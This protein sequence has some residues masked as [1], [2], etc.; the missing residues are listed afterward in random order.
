MAT[1]TARTLEVG[2]SADLIIAAIKRMKRRE[3]EEFIE[4][5]L[6]STSPDYLDSIRAA[7]ADKRAGRTKTVDQV[8]GE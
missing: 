5:L 3:R 2:L 4:D 1:G 6:A 7:R 8:F